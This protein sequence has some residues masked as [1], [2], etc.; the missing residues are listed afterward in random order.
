[1][2]RRIS[3]ALVGFFC[4]GGVTAAASVK[5]QILHASDLEGGVGAIADAP[6]FAAVVEALEKRAT[7]LDSG[8]PSILLSA[9]DNYIPGPFFSAAADRKGLR[10]VLRQTQRTFLKEPGL[11]NIREGVGRVDITIMNVLGFDASALGNHEFDP[12]TQVLRE[13]IGPDVRGSTLNDI[14]WLGAQFP[15][16]S[17]NLDFS[18]DPYLR[19]IYTDQILPSTAFRS[20]ISSEPETISSAV[21]IAPATTIA[22]DV[23]GIPEVVGVIGATTPRLESISYPGDTTVKAQG[24]NV[25]DMQALASVLQ[26]VIDDLINGADRLPGTSDDINKIVLVTHLQQILLEQE[27][28]GRLR[29]VDIVVAGGSDTLLADNNDTLRPGD[30]AGGPYPI[31][32][33]NKDGDPAL[34]VGTVG[35]YK[36]V[37]RLVVEFNDQGKLIQPAVETNTDPSTNISGV[38]ATDTDGVKR[39]WGSISQPFLPGSKGARVKALTDAVNDV[40]IRKDS[41]ILGQTEVFL[42]GR[43]FFVRTEE[44][45]LG[46]LTADAILLAGKRAEG[47]LST[48]TSGNRGNGHSPV[49]MVSLRN[50]GGIRAEIGFIDGNTGRLLP[51]RPNPVS[52][53]QYGEISQ[54]DIENTLKFNNGL[55]LLTITAEQLKW[56]LEHAVAASKE[57]NTPGQFAH[58]GGMAFSF[59]PSRQAIKF[60]E[61]GVLD[62]AGGR[63]RSMVITRDGTCQIIVLEGRLVGDPTEPIRLVTLDFLADGG[64]A[65]P[66]PTFGVD[67][68]D[69]VEFQ[70]TPVGIST[71]ATDGSEQDALAEYLAVSARDNPIDKIETPVSQDQRIQNLS[72]RSDTV[73]ETHCP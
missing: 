16:L 57:G 34:V 24:E 68:K 27:L 61:S 46:N 17:A 62:Q 70:N 1:M 9:G 8:I 25:D 28:I 41:N 6:N 23:D 44:T 52:G 65:Y 69:L 21:K 67:R 29:G 64:D 73:I 47:R 58:V 55:S 60:S 11:G 53:K 31:V 5:L 40:V 35:Q 33:V 18:N 7:K 15:Y 54:L 30:V 19:E 49:P 71:F 50:G 38:Y 72:K 48:R 42:E 10:T 66:L 51:T 43:R 36:Y 20:D 22:I 26:P 3:Y 39:L 4:M 63:V 2:W 14:R 56:T 13:I 32:T 12:G 59:D 45:N 37:G